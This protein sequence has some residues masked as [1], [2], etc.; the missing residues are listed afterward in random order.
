M[1]KT[2]LNINQLA[3]NAI[4]TNEALPTETGDKRSF[5]STEQVILDQ[6]ANAIEISKKGIATCQEDMKTIEKQSDLIRA[7]LQQELDKH[8]KSNEDTESELSNLDSKIEQLKNR[9]AVLKNTPKP[10]SQPRAIQKESRNN[11]GL[12]LIFFFFFLDIITIIATWSTQRIAFGVDAIIER[13]TYVLLGI[14]GTSVALHFIYKKTGNKIAIIG[15]CVGL[16][17]SLTVAAHVIIVTA[18]AGP[19]TTVAEFDLN[20]VETTAEPIVKTTTNSLMSLLLYHPGLAE[21][22]V[23]AFCVVIA[24]ISVFISKI[25]PKEGNSV[26][27][28]SLQLEGAAECVIPI[29][30]TQLVGLESQRRTIVN[31][32]AEDDLNF[33]ELCKE[34]NERLGQLRTE[35]NDKVE[36]I[37]KYEKTIKDAIKRELQVLS[38]LRTTILTMMSMIQGVPESNFVY[39]PASEENVKAHFNV[40]SLI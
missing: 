13:I 5:T 11:L 24:V 10:I 22:F 16:L 15:I 33:D 27:T 4:I 1:N 36:Q 30:E 26:E 21:F 6:E 8:K 19:E 2:Q 40:T 28:P 23:M 29:L 12:W 32:R 31:K 35:F 18:M 39:A 14:F 7:D 17:M 25:S 3:Q 37:A 20:L 38:I 34:Y 9:I